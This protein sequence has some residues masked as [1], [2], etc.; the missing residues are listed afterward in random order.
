MPNHIVELE[1]RMRPQS[2]INPLL[3]IQVAVCQ[4]E[5]QRFGI[6]SVFSPSHYRILSTVRAI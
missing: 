5:R 6:H 3:H 4:Q 2:A 1:R